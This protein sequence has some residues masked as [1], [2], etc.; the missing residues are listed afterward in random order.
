M[1]TTQWNG[2][3]SVDTA[4]A[5]RR[6]AARTGKELG[7]TVEALVSKAGTSARVH[8][9]TASAKGQLLRTAGRLK[10]AAGHAGRLVAR[11]T[12]D[13]A[14]GKAG[15]TRTGALGSRTALTATV[16]VVAA[17]AVLARWSRRAR[18]GPS[19]PRR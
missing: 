11:A 12:P 14:R 6:Q 15:R 4:R 17:A 9:K 5:L 13:P 1:T 18:R 7:R 10:A 16:G 8:E 3:K 19:S 2:A